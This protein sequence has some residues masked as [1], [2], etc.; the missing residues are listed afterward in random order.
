V[1]PYPI[2][3]VVTDES[4]T[5]DAELVISPDRQGTFGAERIVLTRRPNG[6]NIDARAIRKPSVAQLVAKAV[7]AMAWRSV[8]VTEASPFGGVS[9]STDEAT[10]AYRK[11]RRPRQGAAVTD[12]QLAIVA[13]TYRA[14]LSR[15]DPPTKSVAETLHLSRATAGRQVSMARRRGFLGPALGPV[16][17]EEAKR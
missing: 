5:F 8:P 10:V 1:V 7:D 12:D 6:P 11:S 4:L 9:V 17:G 14:A 3:V 16:A 15:G 2:R 13:D